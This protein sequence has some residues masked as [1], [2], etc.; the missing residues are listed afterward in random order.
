M[1]SSFWERRVSSATRLC[2]RWLKKRRRRIKTFLKE[3][4]IMTQVKDDKVY[5]SVAVKTPAYKFFVFEVD[6]DN[7]KVK[8]I[9]E[10]V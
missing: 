10:V 7:K 6:P 2:K 9:L 3:A 8:L 4:L 1:T 5:V